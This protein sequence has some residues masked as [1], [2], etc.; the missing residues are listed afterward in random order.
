MKLFIDNWRWGG[1]PFLFHTQGNGWP[2]RQSGDRDPLQIDADATRLQA[3][4]PGVR[5]NKLTIADPA[6]REASTLKFGLKMPGAGLSGTGRSAWISATIVAVV[7][8]PART[9]T[10]GCCWTRCSAI[11]RSMPG[12]TA[13]EASWRIHRPDPAGLGA[14]PGQR[15]LLH[16]PGA[17][18]RGPK[19]VTICCTTEPE[20]PGRKY[21]RALASA[22]NNQLTTTMTNIFSSRDSREALEL[23]SEQFAMQVRR[24]K[25]EPFFLAL[26]RRRDRPADVPVRG[27]ERFSG[28]ID[29][30]TIRFYWVDETHDVRPETPKAI[31]GTPTNCCSGR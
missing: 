30:D 19:S 5:C 24:K 3:S 23:L 14:K 17:D 28:R 2:K 25:E 22:G 10:N 31:T 11:R 6:G 16:L 7:G 15:G 26:S 4:A 12:R 29:W 20:P 18:R 27:A 21:L 1:V 8:L 9:L 13:L